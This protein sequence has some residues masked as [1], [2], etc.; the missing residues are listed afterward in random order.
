[1]KKPKPGAE[2]AIDKMPRRTKKKV[3]YFKDLS[4]GEIWVAPSRTH[5]EALFYAF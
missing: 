5:T 2:G 1:M 3:R 4:L